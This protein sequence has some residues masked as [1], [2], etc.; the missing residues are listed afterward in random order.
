MSPSA[1]LA[2]GVRTPVARSSRK[3]LDGA[4]L[5]EWLTYTAL[6]S[7]VKASGRV[8]RARL[9]EIDRAPL[10][11][12]VVEAVQHGFVVLVRARCKARLAVMLDLEVEAF[13]GNVGQQLAGGGDGIDVVQQAAFSFPII[14]AQHHVAVTRGRDLCNLRVAATTSPVARGATRR[15]TS[16]PLL[17]ASRRLEIQRKLTGISYAGRAVVLTCFSSGTEYTVSVGILRPLRSI[18]T[19]MATCLPSGDRCAWR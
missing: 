6:S 8:A 15:P 2:I 18:L 11:A 7:G 5:G 19:L 17:T 13:C 12:G 16:M 1:W 3:R 4:P 10:P 14:A 9:V